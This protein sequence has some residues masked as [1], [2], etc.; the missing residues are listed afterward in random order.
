MYIITKTLRKMPFEQRKGTLLKKSRDEIELTTIFENRSEA[1]YVGDRLHA[2]VDENRKEC[3]IF[4]SSSVSS[5]TK[6]TRGFK[7]VI[8]CDIVET[9]KYDNLR[10]ANLTKSL[11][12]VDYFKKSEVMFLGFDTRDYSIGNVTSIGLNGIYFRSIP[13]DSK[14]YCFADMK[15]GNNLIRLQRIHYSDVATEWRWA[16]YSYPNGLS[17]QIK[18]RRLGDQYGWDKTLG[19]ATFDVNPVSQNGYGKML[20]LERNDYA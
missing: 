18:T 10:I 8:D 13:S 14:V 11:N 4:A 2:I 5:V 3:Y 9:V 17:A 1:N 19:K 20:T 7:T 12:Y 16:G 15:D 6:V